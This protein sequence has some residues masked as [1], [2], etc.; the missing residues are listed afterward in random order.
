MPEFK[1]QCR[2]AGCSEF[3]A[4]PF[5]KTALFSLLDAF[6]QLRRGR[7]ESAGIQAE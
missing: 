3:L 2:L 4:R 1:R 5:S 7:S 6:A